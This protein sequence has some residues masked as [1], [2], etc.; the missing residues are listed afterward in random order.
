M[1]RKPLFGVAASTAVAVLLGVGWWLSSPLREPAAPSWKAE[2]EGFL[3]VPT[4]CCM[5][6]A[7]WS[8]LD[9]MTADG[10]RPRPATAAEAA[11]WLST[12]PWRSREDSD[13]SNGAELFV[14]ARS[15][16][17]RCIGAPSGP[18]VP[19]EGNDE[20]TLMALHGRRECTYAKWQVW[21]GR[22]A[23]KRPN[24]R[25]TVWVDE[26]GLFHGRVDYWR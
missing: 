18:E 12:W 23:Q 10:Q 3:A 2:A 6:A 20:E 7:L 19:Q 16:E 21:T 5:D 25:H 8:T 4:P 17:V 24:E 22:T 15:R 11:R 14:A 13:P 1:T 26:E 9:T